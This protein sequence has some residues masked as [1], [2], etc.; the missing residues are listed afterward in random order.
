M[1]TR[2]LQIK[3]LKFDQYAFGI[4]IAIELLMSFTFLGYIHVPPI[5]I[6]LAYIPIVI[7]GCLFGT[8]ESTVIG[9]IFGLGSMYKASA[10]YVMEADKV[11]SPFQSGNPCG[12]LMLSVGSRAV[13]GLVIGIAFM[14]VKKV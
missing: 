6:T 2:K 1:K 10:Y 8:I 13:F 11:F 5:S 4:L 3:K 14:L 7:A 9:I 12:S